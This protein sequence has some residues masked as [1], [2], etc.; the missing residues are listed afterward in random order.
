[1]FLGVDDDLPAHMHCQ[2]PAKNQPGVSPKV[3]DLYQLAFHGNR[4][5]RNTRR[6]DVKGRAS[7]K[8]CLGYFTYSGF[9]LDGCDVHRSRHIFRDQVDHELPGVANVPPRVL[10]LAGTVAANLTRFRKPGCGSVERIP[11]A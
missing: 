1:M 10:R 2:H 5:A 7:M 11:A 8:F 4:T 6:F 9:K 3:H